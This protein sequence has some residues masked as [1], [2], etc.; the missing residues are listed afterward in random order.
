VRYGTALVLLLVLLAGVPRLLDPQTLILLQAVRD[1]GPISGWRCARSETYTYDPSRERPDPTLLADPPEAAVLAQVP[2]LEIE[3][4]EANLR[5][6]DTLVTA[7][8]LDADRVYVLAPGTL[9]S[10]RVQSLGGDATLC[11]VHLSNWQIVGEQE[12]G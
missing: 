4:V 5:G 6:G 1:L 11:N 8:E 3:H 7:R 9:Q 12:L 2:W 10:I